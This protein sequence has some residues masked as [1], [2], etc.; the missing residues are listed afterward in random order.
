MSF[1]TVGCTLA[2]LRYRVIREVDIIVG[3]EIEFHHLSQL[4]ECIR[5][6]A[7]KSEV[8]EIQQGDSSV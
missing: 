6:I 2:G 4:T 1:H 3:T 5:H 7:I 8:T